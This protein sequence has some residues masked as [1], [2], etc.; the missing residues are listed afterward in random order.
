MHA[1]RGL[2]APR[3]GVG[4]FRAVAAAMVRVDGP[5]TLRTVRDGRGGAAVVHVVTERA[6]RRAPRVD[7]H[8]FFAAGFTPLTPRPEVSSIKSVATSTETTLRQDGQDGVR[9]LLLTPS[10]KD[11]GLPQC[12]H[13]RKEALGMMDPFP[14]AA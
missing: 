8:Y 2:L 4:G 5:A 13:G 1:E 10:R 6:G 14:V 9:E 11:R 12:G 7:G 3:L